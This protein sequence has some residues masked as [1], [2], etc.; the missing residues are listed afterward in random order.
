MQLNHFW[1]LL[2]NS[3][4]HLLT[5]MNKIQAKVQ[6]TQKTNLGYAR[7]TEVQYGS[8][9]HSGLGDMLRKRK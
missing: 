7:I 9:Q 4:V 3:N 2:Q 8:N 6:L 5:V 1:I